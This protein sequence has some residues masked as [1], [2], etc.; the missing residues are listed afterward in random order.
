MAGKLKNK[1]YKQ[2]EEAFVDSLKNMLDWEIQLMEARG[3]DKAKETKR[4]YGKKIELLNYATY[5]PTSDTFGRM[6]IKEIKKAE[7]EKYIHDYDDMNAYDILEKLQVE[8]E[9]RSQA[10]QMALVEIQSKKPIIETIEKQKDVAPLFDYK[11]KVEA[12]KGVL[13]PQVIKGEEGELNNIPPQMVEDYYI[14]T[15]DHKL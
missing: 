8:Y 10:A 5:R 12:M 11:A 15:Q 7:K 6:H 13:L 14:T 3:E 9:K 1:D 4:E 2:K